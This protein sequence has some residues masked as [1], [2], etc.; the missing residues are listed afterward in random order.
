MARPQLLYRISSGTKHYRVLGRS[1]VPVSVSATTDEETLATITV[2]AN[3]MGPNGTLRIWTT[4]THTNSANN[5]T[6]SVRFSGASGTQYLALVVTAHAGSQVVTTISNR[7]ATNS[8]VG[9]AASAATSFG[10]TIASTP[11]TSAVDT[12]VATTI[13]ISGQKASSGE[14]LT[15]EWY[16][17][18][19]MPGA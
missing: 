3:A 14:T 6:L 16:L 11:A 1:A 13:V 12:T 10:S 8:Q 9:Y 18:E 7:N 4:W 5:K 15:L 2:P 19:L 17:V